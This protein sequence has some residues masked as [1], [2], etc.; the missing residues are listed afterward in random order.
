MDLVTWMTDELDDMRWRLQ[1]S[2]LAAIPVDR[3]K[4]RVDGGGST[5][6]SLLWHLARHQ[7][8]AVNVVTFA[9]EQVLDQPVG[10]CNASDLAP[11]AGLAEA[12]SQALTE[13]LD[14]EG[15]IAYY[16][17]VCANTVSRLAAM[18]SNDLDLV[19]D[20]TGALT[21]LGIADEE[22]PWL[23]RMWD[24]KPS[25]FHIRWEAISHGVTHTGEMVSMRNRMGLSPF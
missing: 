20:A 16:D 23:Y 9:D 7:D 3:H 14:S 4:E 17:A 25:S 12:E 2:V 15:V 5:V 10:R 11:S 13:T 6:T 1:S 19:P 21:S 8:I 24:N 22:V 18:S